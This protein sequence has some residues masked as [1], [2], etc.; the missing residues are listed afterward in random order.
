MAKKS[1]TPA[2]RRRAPKK[3]PTVLPHN[4]IEV[5]R[6]IEVRFR[7]NACYDGKFG[8]LH[9]EAGAIVAPTDDPR[10]VLDQLKRFVADEINKAVGEARLSYAA[11][12]FPWGQRS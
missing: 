10:Q 8:N 11:S 2:P 3:P 4:G 9:V 5:S 7:A 12:G 6:V 1:P